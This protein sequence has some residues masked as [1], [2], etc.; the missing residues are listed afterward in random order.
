[1]SPVRKLSIPALI[2]GVGRELASD[3]QHEHS[4][5]GDEVPAPSDA[6]VEDMESHPIQPHSPQCQNGFEHDAAA[7]FEPGGAKVSAL[8]AAQASA[9]PSSQPAAGP[10]LLPL[11]CVSRL[12]R[13]TP[14]A[15][16]A[17]DVRPGR[18]HNKTATS[19]KAATDVQQP[20][21]PI[22]LPGCTEPR[23]LRIDTGQQLVC[24]AS[25]AN[26]TSIPLPTPVVSLS[27]LPAAQQEAMAAP[28]AEAAAPRSQTMGRQAG[29]TPARELLATVAKRELP[30]RS[31][32]GRAR[33]PDL[34]GLPNAD[35]NRAL[36]LRP[37]K[38]AA[39]QHLQAAPTKGPPAVSPVAL[40]GQGS[41]QQAGRAGP[42]MAVAGSVPPPAATAD[43]GVSE[44]QRQP[45]AAPQ[46]HDARP[47]TA[48]KRQILHRQA[49]V[50][51]V[52]RGEMGLD[53]AEYNRLMKRKREEGADQQ[54]P[55]ADNAV[56]LTA[57]Q[58]TAGVH[59]AAVVSAA[60]EKTQAPASA[61]PSRRCKSSKSAAAGA[62]D[63]RSDECN[64]TTQLRKRL[65]FK[66]VRC[67][68][69]LS[70]EPL[71][72]LT[73]LAVYTWKPFSQI[74]ALCGAQTVQTAQLATTQAPG[75]VAPELH[76][77]AADQPAPNRASSIIEVRYGSGGL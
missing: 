32:K 46:P 67:L 48:A 27:A 15:A 20:G 55:T 25:D 19:A 54:L 77:P 44:G 14:T 3:A 74:V 64:R 13:P 5:E 30:L 63:P 17:I 31:V 62:A 36:G 41:E 18:R 22:A 37:Q 33:A 35:Y 50:Q 23:Q 56:S 43:V 52:N 34:L 60:S 11:S 9:A 26:V 40:D 75:P 66:Q 49:R 71:S 24:N 61:P 69:F 12:T 2:D 47:A 10:A 65:T 4:R 51:K 72:L 68:S 39:A 28:E 6:P 16:A 53:S 58:A 1:M 29:K 38:G 57:A 8:G 7:E 21:P 42:L 73:T 45:A 59:I 76:T 70:S